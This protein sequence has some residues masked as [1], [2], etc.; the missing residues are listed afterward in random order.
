MLT[1]LLFQ[2]TSSLLD[3]AIDA[4]EGSATAPTH[5]AIQLDATHEMFAVHA[6]TPPE[7]SVAVAVVG[8]AGTTLVTLPAGS[9]VVTGGTT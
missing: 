7:P 5:A 9:T 2:P 3:R 1:L 6:T 4:A 8:D